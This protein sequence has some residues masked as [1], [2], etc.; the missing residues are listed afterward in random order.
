MGSITYIKLAHILLFLSLINFLAVAQS[1]SMLIP[2]EKGGLWGYM[3]TS[4]EVIV[5]PSFEEAYYSYYSLSRFKSK[6]KYGYID[7]NGKIVKKA[8]FSYA[9]DYQYGYTKVRKGNREF[10]LDKDG[11]RLKKTKQIGICGTH[12]CLR[13]NYGEQ[14]VFSDAEGKYGIVIERIVRNEKN[15]HMVQDTLPGIYDSIVPISHNLAYVVRKGKIGFLDLNTSVKEGA[16][17]VE[18]LNFEFDDIKFFDCFMCP[19]GKANIF[20]V[21]KD[22]RWTYINSSLE[23]FGGSYLNLYRMDG[24]LG[25]VEYAPGSLGYINRQG[26]EFFDNTK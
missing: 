20:A 24:R 22:G 17:I 23:K 13:L 5:T 7:Q 9:E 12:S 26:V 21:Q 10:F 1:N 14:K 11:K 8:K 15:F 2:F 25:L 18:E 19:Q 4:K 3:N 6:G 16:Q